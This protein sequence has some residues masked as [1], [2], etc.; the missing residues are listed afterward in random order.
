MN[1][2]ITIEIVLIVSLLFFVGIQFKEGLN[3]LFL[4]ILVFGIRYGRF[5]A[6]FTAVLSAFFMGFWSLRSGLVFPP[7]V[8]LFILIGFI[9]G[10]VSEGRIQR[11]KDLEKELKN[12][13]EEIGA[14]KERLNFMNKSQESLYESLFGETT[15]LNSFL[16]FISQSHTEDENQLLHNLPNFVE[17]VIQAKISIYSMKD[18]RPVFEIGEKE[19]ELSNSMLFKEALKQKRLISI[20]EFSEG[21]KGEPL[22]ILP[23]MV[24][25]GMLGVITVEEMPF[26]E[27]RITNMRFLAIL[28]EWLAQRILEVRRLNQVKEELER[29]PTSGAF[30]FSYFTDTMAREKE[31]AKRYGTPLSAL[32]L[33]ISN[34][35]SLDNQKKVFSEALLGKVMEKELRKSDQ[36]FKHEKRGYFLV[37]MPHTTKEGGEKVKEKIQ[38]EAASYG[39]DLNAS[40]VDI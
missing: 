25:E 10:A 5:S 22:A 37:L 12:S 28:G 26:H 4:P 11:N 15:R 29:D 30:Y 8:F 19:R 35:E 7:Q 34:Y 21:I 36:Y 40:I 39:M 31:R 6:I 17:E 3:L 14:L 23:V 1:K 27:F 9:T 16:N 20:K 2:K 38:E 24:P 33:Q 13:E 18:H 32:V